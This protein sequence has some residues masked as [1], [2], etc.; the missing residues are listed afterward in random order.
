MLINNYQ[1]MGEKVV[2]KALIHDD[3]SCLQLYRLIGIS[4]AVLCPDILSDSKPVRAK[5]I[6]PFLQMGLG[7]AMSMDLRELNR[8]RPLYTY[9]YPLIEEVFGTRPASILT[10]PLDIITVYCGACMDHPEAVIRLGSV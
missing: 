4:D 2:F 1:T 8:M 10:T 9:P 3:L 6:S 7:V 5:I